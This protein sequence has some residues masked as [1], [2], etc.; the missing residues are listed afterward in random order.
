MIVQHKP[1]YM[2]NLER[3]SRDDASVT[4]WLWVPFGLEGHDAVRY[5][6][7]QVASIVAMP[8]DEY[9]AV[10]RI[11]LPIGS[12]L[13]AAGVLWGL[14][15][16]QVNKLVVGVKVGKDPRPALDKW[17]PPGWAGRMTL[18]S[19]LQEYHVS[20]SNPYLE[21]VRLDSHYEAKA[22]PFLLPGDLFWVVGIRPTEVE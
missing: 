14:E 3:Y 16:W 2:N 9:K 15:R 12:G 22:L 5:T 4:G 19:A 6:A 7:A 17:A 18:V 11:V 13:S 21:G 8:K 20:A 1:G 10:Q